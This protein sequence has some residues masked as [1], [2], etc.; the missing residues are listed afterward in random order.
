MNFPALLRRL[1]GLSGL[2]AVSSLASLPVH[3]TGDN[4][5]IGAWP[6]AYGKAQEAAII[7]P[8]K[9]TTGVSVD[10]VPQP[11]GSGS[12]VVEIPTNADVIEIGGRDLEAAC[13][14]GDLVPL[15]D[16][17]LEQGADGREPREDFMPQ[18]L[19]RCGV[20]SFVWSTLFIADPVQFK[21]GAPRTIKDVFDVRRFPGKR[22]LLKDPRGLLEMSLAADGVKGDQ[23]YPL[24]A[25]DG[26]L[27]RALRRLGRMRGQIAWV[28]RPSEAL[29]QLSSGEAGLA[30]T[31]SGR[32]FRPAVSNGY[33]LIWDGS[34]HDVTYWAVPRTT[35]NSDA[36]RTFIKFATAPAR[37]AAQSRLWPY[38]PT[39]YSSVGMVGRH[40]LLDV[41]L[42]P[43]LPSASANM[44]RGI[45]SDGAFWLVHRARIEQAFQDWLVA[46]PQ[47]SGGRSARKAS[48]RRKAGRRNRRR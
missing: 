33:K 25:R 18:A 1:T 29:R 35:R 8:F 5:V 27:Q 16:I 26:G 47:A 46:K 3:A 11:A 2:L 10:V 42:E 31:F 17:V 12:A 28:E 20:G 9:D 15:E 45:M 34:V 23:I 14:R 41:A 22:A 39:R 21:K 30:M 4:L 37:L 36:A 19:N 13:A 40:S 6:G 24:L 32:A 44:T 43:Y 7:R 48:G 38:G